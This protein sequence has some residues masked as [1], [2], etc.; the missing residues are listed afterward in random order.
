MGPY[1]LTQD[2]SS[3][4]LLTNGALP[5]YSKQIQSWLDLGGNNASE[6]D[7]CH[8]SAQLFFKLA[9]LPGSVR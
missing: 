2:W 4:G 3:P 5:A 7:P 9:L 8:L 6:H 1:W